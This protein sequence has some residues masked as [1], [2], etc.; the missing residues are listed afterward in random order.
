MHS[1]NK[2]LVHEFHLR[3]LTL[4]IH[5]KPPSF[6]HCLSKQIR[7]DRY[8]RAVLPIVAAE[9]SPS[10]HQ[11]PT[12]RSRLYVSHYGPAPFPT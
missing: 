2:S 5:R 7:L 4:K 8:I 11:L 1:V 12:C 3:E 9:V 6:I 10:P